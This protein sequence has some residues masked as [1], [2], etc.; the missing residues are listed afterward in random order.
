MVAKYDKKLNLLFIMDS[1]L[2][3]NK[4]AKDRNNQLNKNENQLLITQTCLIILLIEKVK[5][6][7]DFFS[8]IGKS[9]FFLC[10]R[11]M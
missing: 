1:N 3:K 5:I 11:K 7:T 8:H 10:W 6:K 9:S 4:M 2:L